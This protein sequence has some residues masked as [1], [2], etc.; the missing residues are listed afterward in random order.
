MRRAAAS[1]RAGVAAVPAAVGAQRPEALRDAG[2]ARRR[3]RWRPARC[4]LA[5]VAAHRRRRPCALRRAA[6][7]GRRRARP[8]PARRCGRMSRGEP[9]PA[10]HRRHGAAGPGARG[11][12]PVHRPGRAVPRHG[13]SALRRRRRCSATSSTAATPLLGADADGRPLKSTCCAAARPKHAAIHETALDAAGAV[14]RRVRAGAAVAVVGR[15]AGRRDRPLRRRVRR[16]L[17]RRR[18][19]ARGRPAADRR[20]RPADAGAAA[21]RRDGRGLRA[22]RRGR[23]RG[24]RR[25]AERLA[26]AAVNAPDSVV[27]SGESAARRG[28]ARR[29]RAR[30]TSRVSACSCRSRPTRRWST[31]IAR[32]D[33]GRARRG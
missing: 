9:H 29:L 23:A 4:R 8:R 21:R 16:R 26:I 24:R 15:R 18:L 22:G 20:A 32:R 14:R 12:V 1:A 11:R 13:A 33:A 25:C 30:A 28:A 3:R 31:P 6:G 2:A 10:L 5:D 19:H 17:R 27:V 7:G